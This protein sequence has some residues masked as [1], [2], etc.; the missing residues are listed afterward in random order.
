[1]VL[2]TPYIN[3]FKGLSR[4]VWLLALITLVNRAGTMVVPFLSLY[5]TDDRDFSLDQ[6]GWIMTSFGLGSVVGA[7]LGGKL[8]DAIGFYR[9]MVLS[10]LVSGVMFIALQFMSTFLWHCIMIF[11]LLVIADC[12]RPAMYV[13]LGVYSKKENRTRSLS[14]IRLAINLGFSFGPALGG[15]I[16]ATLDYGGLF[17]VD[18]LTC[19]GAGLLTISAL[20]R[21]QRIPDVAE[22]EETQ[23]SPY[24]DAPYLVFLFAMLLIA[25]A[26]IQ[27]FSTVPLFY[28][29]VHHLGEDQIGWLLALN[30]LGIF[31]IEMP[32]I[33]YLED[34]N[35]S[36][37]RILVA[38][39]VMFALGFLV[40]NMS[41]WLGVLWISM[42]LLTVGEVLNFP[43]LNA[44]AMSRAGSKPGAYMALFTMTFSIAHVVSH[45]AGMF[46]VDKVGFD[47][48]WY[49]MGVVLTI[50]AVML[51][52]LRSITGRIEAKRR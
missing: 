42:G 21:K 38:S 32:I 36:I 18:G 4:E 13:A 3:S 19:I 11:L 15:W 37:Y 27:L 25:F 45:K 46:L 44:Y 34:K 30:G 29:D 43:F 51:A 20:Q 17:W 40:L 41:T 10:L 48:T 24:R 16:I 47:N 28:R 39:T 49:I 6:V 2:I 5:L 9:V 26:F 22:E 7:W 50:A 33:K 23:R 52:M 31:V 1:M 12:Y 14:L 35:V 8:A